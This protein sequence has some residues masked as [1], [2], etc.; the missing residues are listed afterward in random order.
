M[1]FKMGTVP[2][3]ILRMSGFDVSCAASSPL[4]VRICL[5]APASSRQD[6][7]WA[8]FRLQAQCRQVLQEGSRRA[9]IHRPGSSSPTPSYLIQVMHKVITGNKV[10]FIAALS[11]VLNLWVTEGRA[12][13]CLA[14]WLPQL[15]HTSDWTGPL[16]KHA[17][18]G[19]RR[20]TCFYRDPL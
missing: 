12:L 2:P 11:K 20:A 10:S 15:S 7:T 14:E 18:T 9:G 5:S 19:E 16:S 1:T 8:W 6:T 3:K 17:V 13:F 4:A